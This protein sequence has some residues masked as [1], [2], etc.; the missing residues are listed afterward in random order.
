MS[1]GNEKPDSLSRVETALWNSFLRVASGTSIT[2][3]LSAFSVTAGA[4][5]DGPPR[6]SADAGWF[7]GG[8]RQNLLT[9]P[10]H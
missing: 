9:S 4:I 1:L 7:N 6:S 10:H 2:T 5:V 3:A 8:E